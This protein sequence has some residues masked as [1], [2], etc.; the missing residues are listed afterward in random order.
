[1]VRKIAEFI[2]VRQFFS[3]VEREMGGV[4]W[5]GLTGLHF[6]KTSARFELFLK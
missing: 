1:M 2:K 5:L 3:S 6:H 4:G